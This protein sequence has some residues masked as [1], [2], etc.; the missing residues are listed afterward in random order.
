VTAP[1]VT[2]HRRS[3]A[4]FAGRRLGQTIVTLFLASVVV[5]L[6]NTASTI[7]PAESILASRGVPSASTAQIT[8]VRRSL[9]LNHSQ[10]RQYLHWLSGALRGDFGRSWISGEPVRA[11][12]ASRIEPT[13]LLAAVALVM[14]VVGALVF[15]CLAV[16]VARRWPDVTIRAVTVVAAA[17]PSFVL[18]IFLIHF[19][20]IRF[21]IGE[22]ITNGSTREVLLPAVCVAAGSVAVPTRILR[23][24]MLTALNE[25][26]AQVARARGARRAHVVLRHALLNAL[27]PFVNAIALSASWMIGGTFVVETVFSWPGIGSYLVQSVEQRDI[28]VVQ[29]IVLLSTAAYLAAS[30]FADIVTRVIDPRVGD[31]DR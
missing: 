28:P 15:G 16:L 3:A 29:A 10:V 20:V 18:G 5:W 30:F 6:F 19:V 21:G 27:V 24:S 26:F 17:V 7:N 12:L 8:A 23:S 31:H 2:D 22:V 4:R 9:G 1:I 11:E 13:L 25:D 14:V